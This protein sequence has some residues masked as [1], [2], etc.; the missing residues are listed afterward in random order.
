[1]RAAAR[2]GLALLGAALALGC[3]DSD[4]PTPSA[5]NAGELSYEPLVALGDFRRVARQ[6]DPF[7]D[8]AG[9]VPDCAAE[10]FRF[11]ADQ[12]W[13]EIDTGI[14]GWVTV[15]TNAL[16]AVVVEQRLKLRVS[17]F[18]LDAAPPAEA[19]LGLKLGA[20]DAWSRSLPIPSAARV[21]EEELAS[22]CALPQ[23]SPIFFHVQNH[24]QNTYQLQALEVLR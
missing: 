7:I 21:D 16:H 14:C 23:G 2:P 10:G 4:A 12:A 5:S 15:T 3:A 19:E 8:A 18:D 22:P 11:E 9:A 6:D 17:H 1:M 24:G 20:C 13:L